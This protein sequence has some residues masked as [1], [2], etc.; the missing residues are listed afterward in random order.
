MPNWALLPYTLPL[1]LA[2]I[3]AAA[4]GIYAARHREVRG[5]LPFMLFCAAASWWAF[6]YALE[7]ASAGLPQKVFWVRIEYVA[8]AFGPLCWLAFAL[9][10]TRRDNWLRPRIWVPIGLVALTTFLLALTNDVHGLIWRTTS[11]ATDGPFPTLYVQYGGWFWIHTV[12]SYAWVLIGSILLL[13]ALAEGGIFYRRQRLAL[14]ISV[15]AAWSGNILYLAK[16][17]PVPGLDLTPITSTVTALAVA[18]AL[19]PFRLLDLVPVARH[20][21]LDSMSDAVFALDSQNRILD[22]NK[23][24]G[25]FIGFSPKAAVGRPARQ[26]LG[27]HMDLVQVY[28]DVREAHTEIVRGTAENPRYFE[29]Q[30][31]PLRDVVGEY[32]GRLITLH[33]ITERKQAEAE[34]RQLNENLE[35]RIRERTSE[36]EAL[37][38]HLH[39]EIAQRKQ[40]ELE[41]E[42]LVSQLEAQRTLLETVIDSAPIGII[43][44]DTEMRVL[45]VNAEYARLARTDTGQL[46]YGMLQEVALAPI[47]GVSKQ[48]HEQVLAGDAVDEEDVRYES[49]YGEVRYCDLRFRPVRDADHK[50]IAVVGT[51]SDV[52]GRHELDEQREEFIALASHE[53]RTPLTSIKGFAK[54]SLPAAAETGDKRLLRSLQIINEQSDRL[55]RLIGELLDVSS[56]RRE[57]LPLWLELVELVKVVSQVVSRMK[58]TAPEF[59][60]DLEVP[61]TLIWVNADRQRIEEVL[62][63]LLQNAIKYSGDSRC[64]EVAVRCAEKEVV[65]SI[66]DFGVGIPEGEQDRIFDRF[67]RATNVASPRHTGLGLGL[68]ISYNI[69]S[70]HGGRMWVESRMGTGST[71]YFALPGRN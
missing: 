61:D 25:R 37:N 67:F 42:L 16:I 50:V 43:L 4:L 31:A 14:L 1:V 48:V 32:S 53:L 9:H 38:Q 7:I 28:R 6:A 26:F 5:A 63:N 22:L 66:R 39:D 68:Y 58:L 55:T 69:V 24:A 46:R 29:M 54:I 71:F 10:Y 23:A 8:I 19:F 2:G 20:T 57:S 12:T 17:S 21:L 70:R 11:L 45:G 65:T 30:I 18:L 41:R 52:T 62:T 35:Q 27:D 40:G 59:T 56:I 49:A 47:A 64:I 15:V 13:R 44:Y 60:F 3:A 33:D 34:I 36:L 51:A